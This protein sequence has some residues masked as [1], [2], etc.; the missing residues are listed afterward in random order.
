VTLPVA[1]TVSISSLVASSA[2]SVV[3]EKATST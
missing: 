1:L 2:K 3:P